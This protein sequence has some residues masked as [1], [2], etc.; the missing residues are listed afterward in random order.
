MAEVERSS[1]AIRAVSKLQGHGARQLQDKLRELSDR[2]DRP[3]EFVKGQF[4]QWKAGLKNRHYPNYGE[5][6]IVTAVLTTPVFDQSDLSAASPYYL[7]ALT[8]VIVTCVEDEFVEYRV[9]GRR[10]EPC[11]D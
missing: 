8:I 2:L 9:D 7:E 11:G 10:F 4:V 5:P 6:A 3:H 1:P